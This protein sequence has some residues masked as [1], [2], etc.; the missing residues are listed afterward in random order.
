MPSAILIGETSMSSSI[1][2]A[3]FM[4]AS[5]SGPSGLSNDRSL[6]NWAPTMIG[7]P[8]RPPFWPWF[9]SLIGRLLEEG[10]WL[11]CL[12]GMHNLGRPQ[13]RHPHHG[14]VGD[15]EAGRGADEA[16][17]GD[18]GD[19]AAL[20]MGVPLVVEVAGA[21]RQALLGFLQARPPFL[22]QVIEDDLRPV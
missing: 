1:S 4:L 18:D 11:S 15:G 16:P 9:S 2:G 19:L 21:E 8:R 7:A 12:A 5:P 3:S 22:G 6:M 10:R 17:M 20:G 14:A 13:R